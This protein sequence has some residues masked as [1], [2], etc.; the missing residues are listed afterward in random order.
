MRRQVQLEVEE[1]SV[2]F[3]HSSGMIQWRRIQSCFQLCCHRS[4]Q[5]SRVPGPC[6]QLEHKDS[7]Q[8]YSGRGETET[9]ARQIGRSFYHKESRKCPRPNRSMVTATHSPR[10]QTQTPD[11]RPDRHIL[12]ACVPRHPGLPLTHCRHYDVIFSRPALTSS[13]VSG[14]RISSISLSRLRSPRDG[15]HQ[16]AKP[17]SAS[18]GICRLPSCMES[19]FSFRRN[20]PSS[21]AH[22][23]C[24]HHHIGCPRATTHESSWVR[25]RS[26]PLVETHCAS[27]SD[28]RV[29]C[30]LQ[31]VCLD[32][33]EVASSQVLRSRDIP[34]LNLNGML[35]L[36]ILIG[37][38][39]PRMLTGRYAVLGRP[40]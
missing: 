26:P 22:D 24:R 31:G 10:S 25:I 7:D 6:R 16:M 2:P 3:M 37:V 32:S 40:P 21:S 5:A 30:T 23:T 12:C 15:V 35:L 8:R 33:Q 11:P 9:Q 4:T 34:L 19:S 18:V 13:I 14:N 36:P 27:G 28:R 1:G 17:H 38:I 29:D 20:E 39:R